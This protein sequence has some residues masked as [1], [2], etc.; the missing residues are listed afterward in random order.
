[1]FSVYVALA[2]VAHATYCRQRIS[3]CDAGLHC[4]GGILKHNTITGHF[5]FE[6]NSTGKSRDYRDFIREGTFFIGRGGPGLRKRGSFV[7]ILQIGEGQTCF[8][9]NRGRA[10]VFCQGKNYSMSVSCLLFVNKNTQSVQRPKTCIYE[11]N[12][13]SKFI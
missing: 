12:Y 5:G 10:I 8:I 6:K 1:M 2:C 4:A 7:N 9:C 11:Q 13:Q 3:V